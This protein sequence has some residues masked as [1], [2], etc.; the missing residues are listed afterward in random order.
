MYTYI[1]RSETRLDFRQGVTNCLILQRD[2]RR[3]D[4]RAYVKNN[5]SGLVLANS[6]LLLNGEFEVINLLQLISSRVASC[7][8]TIHST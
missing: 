4:T 3:I 7:V 5:R 8:I 2:M 1:A 6:S